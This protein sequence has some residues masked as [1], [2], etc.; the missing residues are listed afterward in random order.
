MDT[1]NGGIV[2]RSGT[3]DRS[4]IQVISRAICVLR[5]LENVPE[6]L[7]LGEIAKA[8]SLPRSTVQR[9]VAA[10]SNEGFLI[11]ASPT[12]KVRL[13]PAIL[14]L[15][16][17]LDFDITKI[18]RPFLRDLAVDVQ[19][20]VDLS[21]Q[22]GGSAVFVDQILGKRRLIAMSS[23]GE[24]FP[25][26]CSANGKALLA[27]LPPEAAKHALA[28]SLREHADFPLRDPDRLSREL[29]AA[30][31]GFVAFD[32]EE[33]HAGIGAVGTAMNDPA[34]G[35]FAISIPVPMTRFRRTEA[36]LVERLLEHRSR[37]LAK[38]SR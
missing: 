31:T 28:R 14:Q 2:E 11:A 34:G 8:V 23:T 17:S 36:K 29:E 38:L 1:L 7:S 30:R 26:H 6:G 35:L 27:A 37:I 22:R 13:G 4:G 15:A 33:H 18:L 32:R 24:R 10:L 21:I 25:L 3:V 19:E 5:I 9:I 16:A 20:T 12:A